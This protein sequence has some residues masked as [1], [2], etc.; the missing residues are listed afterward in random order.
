MES[1]QIW[2]AMANLNSG[3]NFLKKKGIPKRKKAK[4][5]EELGTY[6]L[7]MMRLVGIYDGFIREKGLLSE[8]AEFE[9]R[10]DRELKEIIGGD[11]KIT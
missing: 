8:L 11:I 10:I 9:K 2:E 7:K 4:T 1:K 5:I 3:F 6:S